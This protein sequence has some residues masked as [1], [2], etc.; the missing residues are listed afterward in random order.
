MEELRREFK[1][2]LYYANRK[3][4]HSNFDLNI[5]FQ[6]LKTVDWEKES[7]LFNYASVDG[8]WYRVEIPPDFSEDIIG[9]LAY[10]E[11]FFENA[12]S[13]P[14]DKFSFDIV[15]KIKSSTLKR[16]NYWEV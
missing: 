16:H 4:A 13:F 3:W 14:M 15:E 11:H 12:Q 2:D 8:L 6:R 1:D 7:V 5:A 10:I 9:A